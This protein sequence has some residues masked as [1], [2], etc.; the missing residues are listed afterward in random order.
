MPQIYNGS[1]FEFTS[2]FLYLRNILSYYFREFLSSAVIKYCAVAVVLGLSIARFGHSVALYAVAIKVPPVT[3]KSV[4]VT[5]SIRQHEPVEV[6]TIVGGAIFKKPDL[7]LASPQ[8]TPIEMKNFK[9]MG[10][11]EGNSDFA[12]ALIEV[13]GEPVR[14]YCAYSISCKSRECLCTV[15]GYQIT[16]I[17]KEHIII[18][19]GSDRKK[20]FIGS[21]SSEI[22]SA[23]VAG[24]KELTRPTSGV[25]IITTQVSKEEFRRILRAD[26]PLLT[27][28]FGPE[29]SDGK[30][31]G[32]RIEQIPENHPFAKLGAKNGDVVRKV[33]GYALN[34]LERLMDI[35]KSLPTLSEAN[36]EVERGGVTIRYEF[37]IRN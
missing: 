21:S 16:S 25:R 28:K 35:Y 27:G 31:T 30:I 19:I 37:H 11:L 10:T 6:A 36:V 14:E 12:R 5:D 22:I 1:H 4:T 8:G 13:Q 32:Y 23:P 20:L 17:A 26:G 15:Q 7:A 24:D 33:N 29:V 9:L 3:A 34:D 18:K 2:F